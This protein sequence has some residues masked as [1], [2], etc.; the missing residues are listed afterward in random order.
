VAV[1]SVGIEPTRPDVAFAHERLIQKESK[2]HNGSVLSF[3]G[4]VIL[5]VVII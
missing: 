4:F 5:L 3:V 1:R 2:A